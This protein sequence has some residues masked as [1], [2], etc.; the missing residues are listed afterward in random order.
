LQEALQ[1]VRKHARAGSVSVSLK[2]EAAFVQLIVKDDGVGFD[3]DQRSS[4]RKRK[5][6]LGLLGMRERATYVGGSVEIAS[7]RRHGT[8]ITVRIPKPLP[9]VKPAAA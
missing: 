2:E 9:A 1:N 8:E 7:A 5:G 3:A 4:A 6:T